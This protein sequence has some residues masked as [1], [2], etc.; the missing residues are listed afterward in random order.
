MISGLY[1]VA[2]QHL[3]IRFILTVYYSAESFRQF[4]CAQTIAGSYSVYIYI[5]YAAILHLTQIIVDH[6]VRRLSI[7]TLWVISAI[8]APE[9]SLKPMSSGVYGVLD[10]PA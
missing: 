7:F 10:L 6:D 5:E 3:L 8:E 2:A 1:C 4:S 9:V